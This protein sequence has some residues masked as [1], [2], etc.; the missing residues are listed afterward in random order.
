M[1]KTCMIAV[2]LFSI[3]FCCGFSVYGEQAPNK[4]IKNEM[5][6]ALPLITASPSGKPVIDGKLDDACWQNSI[7]IPTLPNRSGDKLT[8]ATRFFISYDKENLYI[9][10][11]VQQSYLDPVYNLLDKIKPST[12]KRDDPVYGDDSIEV[13]LMPGDVYYQFVVNLDGTVYDGKGT[14]AEWNSSLK[15][16]TAKNEKSW[17]VEIAIPF[18]DLGVKDPEKQTWR[19]NF[20]RN[21]PAKKETGAWSPTEVGFHTLK[22][23]GFLHFRPETPVIRC[24]N[25]SLKS[26]SAEVGLS[27][28]TREALKI[29]GLSDEL[30]IAP[31]TN[32]NIV[33]CLKP[34]SDGNG[35]L[36]VLAGKKEIFRTPRLSIKSKTSEM[37]AEIACPGNTIE[38]F[39]NG[40]PVASSRDSVKTPLLLKDDINTVT[41]KISGEAASIPSGKFAIAGISFSLDEWLCSDK[42]AND[43]NSV[44]FDDSQWELYKGEKIRTGLFFRHTLIKNRT[45][46]APQLE[47][48]TLYVA[49]KAPMCVSI[50]I[51]SPFEKPLADY[52]CHLTLPEGLNIPLYDPEN[53][54][55]WSWH[56]HKLCKNS[57]NGT[58]EYTFKFEKPMPKLGYN[59]INAITLIIAPAFP[60]AQEKKTLKGGCYISGRGMHEVPGEFNVAVL[61]SLKGIQ[62]EN[63]GI[64][65]WTERRGTRN[66]N[67]ETES[68][69]KTF[70]SMGLNRLGFYFY[71]GTNSIT[72]ATE[73]K[74]IKHAVKKAKENNIEPFLC[75]FGNHGYPFFAD[76]LTQHP[77][78]QCGDNALK[79]LTW[80]T[81]MCP[82]AFMSVPQIK[83]RLEDMAVLHDGIMYDV[84][85]GIKSACLCEK[86]RDNFAREFKLAKTPSEKEIYEKYQNELTRYQ[87][88]INFRLFNFITDTAKKANPDIKS[89]VYS[90]Y[91]VPGKYNPLVRYGMD[92]A[93][94]RD[95]VDMPSAGYSENPAIIRET[96][97]L[98]GNQPLYAGLILNSNWYENQYADQNIKVRLFSQMIQGGFGGVHF[99]SWG[100]LNGVGMTAV[101]EFARGVAAYES[102][103]K[104]Q[105]EIPNNGFVTG[106][107]GE[108]I[109]V[110]K[111]GNEYLYIVLNPLSKAREITAKAPP[112]IPDAEIYDFYADRRY[113][114][115]GEY[116]VQAPPYDV[117]L[118]HISK[119]GIFDFLFSPKKRK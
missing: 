58:N 72:C 7:E 82:E 15:A 28:I 18:S 92:W 87:A 101:A 27:A 44:S 47:K 70:R 52:T 33:T 78:Y 30:S 16:V 40:K 77:E 8:E 41:L 84:E 71:V 20:C 14:D 88:N 39:I 103:L 111:K 63:I 36:A 23:F 115:S 10:A 91:D 53:R 68:L 50:R 109:H 5:S 31:G 114:Q 118:L 2:I 25:I 106:T 24:E 42:Q 55:Y 73:Y 54:R 79:P 116:K 35:Q 90:G 13:F 85:A 29:L 104:E 6:E 4:E 17:T 98:I 96:R 1:K 49:N 51:G 110:Y 83:K 32:R 105:N 97:K 34:D 107:A 113:E 43:W 108:N 69:F 75:N 65:S 37:L 100:E 38:I 26:G 112:S 12:S 66:S 56:E 76:I 19:A 46:F 95:I 119:P 22:A 99:F 81:S 86:C 94:Y 57:Q 21:N 80:D 64:G 117:V 93:L 3:N 60:E 11:E 9:G 61:P 59:P 74:N 62:P 89:L 48:N 45:L 102:F 67:A